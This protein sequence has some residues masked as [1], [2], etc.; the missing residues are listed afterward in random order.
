ML[1]SVNR[2][3]SVFYTVRRAVAVFQIKADSHIACRAHAVPLP[4][5]AVR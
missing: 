5:H 2:A 3:G 4:C 1:P